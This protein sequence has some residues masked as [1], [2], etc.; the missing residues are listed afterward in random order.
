MDTSGDYEIG[1]CRADELYDLVDLANR[2]FR[3]GRPGD[4]SAEYPLVFEL[5]NVEH[6]MVARSGGRVVSHAGICLRD[7]S[8]LGAPVRVSSIGAVATDPE[9]RGK[10]LASRLMAEARRHSVE[11]GASL[12]LISGGR[13]MYHRLG[14]VEVGAF[15]RYTV[16][17]GPPDPNYQ[18][19]EFHRDDLP[20]VVSLYQSEPVRFIRPVEDWHK[21]VAASMLMNQPADLLVVRHGNAIVAY[22]GVQRPSPGAKSADAAARVRE[23][24]G[25][26]GALAAALP[27]VARQYGVHAADVVTWR[28]DA[29][30]RAQA[31]T[32][33]WNW[34]QV[35]FAGT[36][37]I[38]DPTRF[39][40]AVRPLLEERVGAELRIEAEGE[41]A[42]LSAGEESVVLSSM[43]ELTALVFGGDT[44]EA[45]AIP[46]LPPAVRAAADRAFPLPLLWYGYNYV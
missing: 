31:L 37:G 22:A 18:V 25:S 43:A 4:M 16:P 3:A 35:P 40:A 32:R 42:R 9:H 10:G 13:G 30:W 36:L 8:I 29:E 24:A 12:M 44:E 28:A 11:R 6:L 15:L 38:I 23:M 7:A 19:S 39:L 41:G 17:A 5:P 46:E 20:A 2:V 34:S 1:P 26:R 33:G 21:L 27:G 14:Y 45:H